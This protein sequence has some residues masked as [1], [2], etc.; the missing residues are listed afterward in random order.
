MQ[1]TRK[2]GKYWNDFAHVETELLA[3]IEEYGTSGIMPIE[4]ELLQAGRRD[5]AKAIRKN[6]GV[7]AVAQR[8]GLQLPSHK[9]K[10]HGYWEDFANVAFELQNFIA[11]HG[12]PGVMPK[13]NELTRA[14][15]HSLANAIDHHGG[16]FVVAQRLGL[17]LSHAQHPDGYWDDF[18]NIERELLAYIEKCGT[19]EVM[20]SRGELMRANL[21]DLAGAFDKY[22]GSSAVAE[23][24]GLRMKI[25]PMGH[26]DDFTNVKRELL[27]FIQEQ[28]T[29]DVMPTAKALEDVGRS[30][31]IFAINKHGG[32]STVA[33]RLGLQLSSTAM[34]PG[35]W[36]SV[37]HI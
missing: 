17:R 37:S 16:I 26:W 8:L 19:Q 7:E 11:E 1:Y 31:L 4:K 25:K 13:Q 36:D 14:G 15:Y 30:N 6:N 32:M 22:G 29:P 10:R 23:R 27:A 2:P 34:P 24:L 12:T 33:G 35:Y 9:R 18:V 20:P 5:L 28:G 21:G 3:F